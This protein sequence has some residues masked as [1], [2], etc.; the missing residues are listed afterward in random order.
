MPINAS[1]FIYSPLHND[2]RR[3]QV[4]DVGEL[5]ALAGS[6]LLYRL[7]NGSIE[8]MNI[9]N[10]GARLPLPIN[11]STPIVGINVAN[12]S[13]LLAVL[14]YNASGDRLVV[15]NASTLASTYVGNL[16]S[17]VEGVAVDYRPPYMVITAY[18]S[19]WLG[20]YLNETPL[21][22]S[23]PLTSL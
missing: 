5:E 11:C 19:T 13:D 9:S 17:G 1:V 7:I 20:T 15:V 2:A 14:C 6:V 18:N 8:A 10:G 22:A 12:S 21:Q 3:F 4:G 23:T 16:S